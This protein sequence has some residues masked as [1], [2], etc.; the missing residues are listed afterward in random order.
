MKPEYDFG[1]KVR[2]VRNIRDV[3]TSYSI[4]YTKLY[5]NHRFFGFFT[6]TFASLFDNVQKGL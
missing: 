1:D 3:I 4:H 2:V 5:E 6:R